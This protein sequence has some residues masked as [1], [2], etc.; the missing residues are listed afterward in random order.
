M[1]PTIES[2]LQRGYFPKELPPPFNTLSFGTK[3]SKIKK[4]WEA[5]LKNPSSTLKQKADESKENYKERKLNFSKS[6]KSDQRYI[7][8]LCLRYSISKGKLSRRYVGIPNPLNYLYLSEKIIDAWDDIIYIINLSKYSQSKPIYQSEFNKRTFRTSSLGVSEFVKKTLEASYDKKVELKLDLSKFY[9]TIY[10]HSISWALLGKEKAKEIYNK[11]E[12]EFKALIESGDVNAILYNKANEIDIKMRNCQGKQ[13]IGIPI[14]PD[15]SYIIGE[16]INSRIDI[17]LNNHNPNLTGCRYYD[18]YYLYTNTIKEAEDTFKYIQ[19]KLHQFGLDINEGKVRIRKY[20]FEFEEKFSSELSQFSFTKRFDYSIKLYFNIIWKFAEENPENTGQ[21]FR[22]AL[23]IFA[24]STIDRIIVPQTGWNTFENLLL[25]TI[26]LDP[27][28]LNIAC[29]ILELYK[30]FINDK[31]KTKL[32]NI[33]DS[34]FRE[35]IKTNQHLEVSWALWICKKFSLTIDREVGINIIKMRDAISCLILLDIIHNTPQLVEIDAALL[36]ELSDLNSSFT[37]NSL[38]EEGWLLVYEGTKK[39]WLSRADLIEE[40]IFFSLLKKNNIEFYD[41]SFEVDFTSNEYI[42]SKSELYIT[43]KMK[44]TA[45]E[46]AKKIYN[47][48]IERKREEMIDDE[49]NIEETIFDGSAESEDIEEE[50]EACLTEMGAYQEIYN[51]ILANL[52]EDMALNEE[53]MILQ[54]LSKLQY[55]NLYRD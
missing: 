27:T 8:S 19:S 26:I 11:S 30:E 23:K 32:Q 53:E 47:E 54:Y 46:K 33:I 16:L 51:S 31:S 7:S 39:G 34:I 25:K 4:E 2:F 36:K 5:I 40:N 52:F 6:F 50:L 28:I 3:Y 10:T 42:F 20:P 18:D 17:Y 45:E 1:K 44:M 13:T 12:K 37:N 24:P 55:F 48:I 38:T 41:S 35:H 49:D 15:I 22:Y 21:I 43:E 14:G 9:P 29:N